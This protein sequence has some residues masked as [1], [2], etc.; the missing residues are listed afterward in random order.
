VILRASPLVD[1]GLDAPL[2]QDAVDE[3]DD[4]LA[5]LVREGFGLSEPVEEAKVT[6]GRLLL[7]LAAIEAEPELVGG[8]LEGMGEGGGRLERGQN[9]VALVTGDLDDIGA[10]EVRE[11]LL[12]QA[13]ALP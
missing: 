11:L 12:R 4:R 10:H 7:G 13:T 3:Q 1:L 9:L 2:R 6:D 8:D 5:V